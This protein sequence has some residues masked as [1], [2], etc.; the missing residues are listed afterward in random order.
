MNPRIDEQSVAL[1]YRL[2]GVS[3]HS[4]LEEIKAAR[5]KLAKKFHPDKNADASALKK[6]ELNEKFKLIQ[7]AYEFITDNF[8]KIQAVLKRFIENTFTQNAATG[9]KAHWVYSSVAGFK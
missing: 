7:E 1:K 3:M 4:S 9:V 6:E 5:N 2:L 8:E